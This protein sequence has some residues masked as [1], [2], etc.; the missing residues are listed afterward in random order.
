MKNFN[1]FIN[2]KKIPYKKELCPDIWKGKTLIPRI[3]DKL[4][5]IARDFFEDLK[6]DTEIVDIQI[7]GSIANFNYTTNSDLDIHILIDFS[8]INEDIILVKKAVDGD[9]FM[10]NLRHNIV[11][12]GHDV[13]IYVQDIN[14]KLASSGKYSL[15][16]HKWI[17]FPTYN[18]PNVDT[19]DIEPKYNARV[20]DIEKLAKL[21]KAKLDS[22]EAQ[23][24][25]EK[26]KEVKSKIQKA[27]KAGLENDP[28]NEFSIENLVF[29]KLRNEGKIKKLIDTITKLYDMIYSQ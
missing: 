8:D 10:W 24:Y 15:M 28:S 11:I 9:R 26:A 5:R 3:E 4:L 20:Y 23:M 22:N 7:V 2:E 6:L 27:R 17:K 25:Y 13:E 29:K 16:N 18:P 21:A 12:K 14:E 1:Q 19:K